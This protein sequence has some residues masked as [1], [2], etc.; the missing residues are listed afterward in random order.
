MP[1][2]IYFHKPLSEEHKNK[3]SNSKKGVKLSEET[4]RKISE[5]SLKIW[6]GKNFSLEHRR[7]LREA[8]LGYK[9]LEETKK[10]ISEFHRLNGVKPKPMFGDNNSS[11]RPEVRLKNS[12]SHGG[13]KSSF[14]KGGIAPIN[15][16]IRQSLEYRLWRESIFKRDSWTCVWCFQRGGKLNADHIKMFAFYP[17]LRFDIDN[18]QTLCE[19]CH[20]WKIK[21]D[22]KIFTGKVPILNYA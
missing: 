7:K 19:N 10:K 12:L 15:A 20:K 13:E 6:L 22:M 2:G 8:H 14:W 18:G 9:M 21:W 1:S 5:N 17:E 3:I 4:K 11:K 16:I